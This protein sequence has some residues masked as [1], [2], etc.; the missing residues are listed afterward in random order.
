MPK[1]SAQPSAFAQIVRGESELRPV[2]EAFRADE[3]NTTRIYA[4]RFSPTRR[5]KLKA[6]YTD[7]LKELKKLPFS[8]LSADA[9]VD[10]VLF[11]NYL[12]KNL[13][14]L[15]LDE[16]EHQG[17]EKLV[18]FYTKITDLEETRVRMETINPEHIAADLNALTK[19]IDALK[20]Q[21]GE[22]LKASKFEGNA[23]A[24]EVKH[25]KGLLK[26]WFDF[27]NGYDP[28]FTWW[29]GEPYKALDAELD[30]YFGVLKE[31]VVGVK[32]DDEN[33]IIGKPI[34]RDGLVSALKFAMIPYT[35]EE[36]LKIADREYAWCEAEM[37][38]AS[39]QLGYG[40]D[41]RKALEY[42]KDL[43]VE[44][45]QQ[46]EMI[47]GLALEAIKFLD[48]H[49]LVTVPELA[50][51]SWKMEMMSPA[52]QLV[53]PFFLGGDDILVSYPTNTMTHDQKMMSMRGNNRYFSRA[54]VQ[55][56]LIPGHHLQFHML[57]RYKP[58]REMFGTPF[59]IEGW[60]LYWEMQLWDLG[61]ASKPEEKIGM[62]FWRMHRC[63][64]IMFSLKFHL[65][66]LTPEQC[67]D[68]L[69]AKV[70]HERANAEG[71]V[72]RSFGG[73]Y[74]PLYQLAYMIG[75]LQFRALHHEL[76]DSGKMTNRAFH[77]AILH[78]NEMPV[79]MVRAI[80][81]HQS[82]TK[83]FQSNWKFDH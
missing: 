53:S 7:A 22:K 21:V 24:N 57:S 42:I 68:M 17:Y 54:T 8:T 40:D 39:N 67:V 49:D 75:G 48:D 29:V 10:Y 81:T 15:R 44:P 32:K 33:A 14:Q 61:F 31:K 56:E 76:V 60:A 80:L 73:D 35:P 1:S 4:I 71:E 70:G 12:D 69:V 47:K 38:K 46:P 50:K 45:G 52:R 2:L 5:V 26:H 28:M 78:E 11:R 37:K 55:H 64:R 83:D 30:A 3:D 62:L 43:H 74:E 13:D 18:P 36:L 41:W 65:G 72:R 82:L 63:V 16:A 20:G 79:E 6:L 66:E 34:G 51:E 58:Y 27:Y 59:W 25:L 77:D 19:E 23:A 9:Q